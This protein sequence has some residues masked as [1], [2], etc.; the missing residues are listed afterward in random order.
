M[1]VR[2]WK[3]QT[4]IEEFGQEQT[5]IYDTTSTT[6]R[7]DPTQ[8]VGPFTPAQCLENMATTFTLSPQLIPELRLK[9]WRQ[10]LPPPLNNLLYP[11]KKG[12][13]VL[14]DVG[15]KLDPNGEDLDLC[16]NA[17]LLGHLRIDMPFYSVN[18]G[19]R[20]VALK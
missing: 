17:S 8:A 15:I 20:D 3:R 11:Y 5:A 12:Y 10:A 9:I 7:H 13:W 18:R 19:A 14:E 16:F 1:S 4:D 6:T 2:F